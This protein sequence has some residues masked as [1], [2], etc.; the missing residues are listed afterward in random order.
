MDWQISSFSSMRVAENCSY[1]IERKEIEK[2]EAAA[3]VFMEIVTQR[4]FPEFVTICLNDSYSFWSFQ[5]HK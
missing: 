4:E 5:W 3:V 2:P 1:S